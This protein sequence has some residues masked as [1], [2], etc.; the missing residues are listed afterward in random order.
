MLGSAQAEASPAEHQP[1]LVESMGLVCVEPC[2]EP[3]VW[4]PCRRARALV[5]PKDSVS[6]GL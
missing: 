4:W 5:R 6:E 3:V 1:C 2:E